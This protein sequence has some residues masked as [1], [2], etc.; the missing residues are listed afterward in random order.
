M[1]FSAALGACIVVFAC[2]APTA[3]AELWGYIDEAGV[4]HFATEQLDDRYQLF[5]KG[6]TTLDVAPDD[7]SR[8]TAR[9]VLEQSPLYRRVTAH[10]N[11]R[12]FASMIE[13]NAKASSL[14][15]ALVKAVIAVESAFEPNAVSPK[16]A[17]GLMQ[18]V[19]ATAARYGL[20]ARRGGTIMQQLLDPA[21]NVRTGV[22]Y[23]HDLLEI[24]DN[25]LSLA[26][27]AYNAGEESVRL[28]GNRIPPFRETQ[29]YVALVLQFRTLYEPPSSAA[30]RAGLPRIGLHTRHSR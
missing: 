15:P 3:S 10:P 25:D 14:D 4:A 26:L 2:H 27:A 5:F 12:R 16:G 29:A 23:L 21:T 18:I 17:V 22:R 19:P 30:S 13:R 8:Q 20:I 7:S 11:V 6:Q 24:F 9:A 28:R 1:R